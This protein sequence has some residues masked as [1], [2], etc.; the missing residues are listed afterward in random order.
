MQNLLQSPCKECATLTTSYC[1]EVLRGAPIGS[2]LNKVERATSILNLALQHV[3]LKRKEMPE[4]AELEKRKAR[5]MQ[6]TTKVVEKWTQK[7]EAA[8]QRNSGT[9]AT[10][11]SAIMAS[12]PTFDNVVVYRKV[13]KDTSVY[14]SFITGFFSQ[15]HVRTEGNLAGGSALEV[16]SSLACQ[17]K[18]VPLEQGIHPPEGNTESC[19]QSRD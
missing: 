2:Y 4:W 14:N 12:H 5:S 10:Q 7:K 6:N 3:S 1:C 11:S 8:L 17:Q 18:A 16:L 13:M 15:T 19:P 9:I